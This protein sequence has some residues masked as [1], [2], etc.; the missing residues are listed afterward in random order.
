MTYTSWERRHRVSTIRPGKLDLFVVTLIE[1][2]RASIHSIMD[3]DLA[4]ARAE[5]FHGQHPCQI[6]VLP[7]TG[8]E[9]RNFL[10]INLPDHPQPV[11]A[12]ERQRLI[13]TLKQIA[14]DS[15]EPDARRD[16]FDLLTEMGVMQS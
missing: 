5:D 16:A 3:Y 1:G 8:G 7:M 15:A 12:N 2:R 4:L 6:K 11:D 10:G 14:R 13:A 9:A